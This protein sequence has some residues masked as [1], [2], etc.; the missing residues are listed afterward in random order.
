VEGCDD[1]G[2][3]GRSDDRGKAVMMTEKADEVMTGG[4]L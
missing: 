1:D 3:N 4:R 2:K